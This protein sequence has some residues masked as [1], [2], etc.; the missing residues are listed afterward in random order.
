MFRYTFIHNPILLLDSN[1]HYSMLSIPCMNICLYSLSYISENRVSYYIKELC[2]LSLEI[3]GPFMGEGV[4]PYLGM[5]GRFHGD[6]PHFCDC[7]TDLVPIVWTDFPP[8]SA[9]IIS[10]CLSHLVPKIRGH[11]V[12]LI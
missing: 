5:V 8:L 7:T 12:G 3:Q 4:L 9:E 2:N 6:D 1:Y 11:K 10:L